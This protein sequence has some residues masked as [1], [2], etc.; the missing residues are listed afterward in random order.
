[1]AKKNISVLLTGSSGFI[2]RNLLEQIG[3]KYDLL[4][5]S[6]SELDL[7]SAEAVKKYLQAH[8]VDVLVHAASRGVIRKDRHA[9]GLADANMSMFFNL[10][11]CNGSYR[12]M[13]CLGSGAEYD[14][15]KPIIRAREGEF[16]RSIPGD[17]YGVYKY[18]CARHIE[19]SGNITSLRLFGCFGKYEDY[20]TR[21]ISNA[22]CKS[23]F[24]LPITIANQNV[25]F[26]YLYVDD[27][28]Q[29]IE[30]FIGH[31]GAHKFYNV[32]PDEVVDLQHIAEEVNRISGK[33]LP[34]IVKNPIM[35]NE[36]SGDNSR[37]KKEIPG[38]RFTKIDE[39]MRRLYSWYEQNLG[40]IDKS[41]LLA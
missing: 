2:G 29:V 24:N 28:A 5:P 17:A 31:E 12:K 20:E 37:L 16:G 35:G 21:F 25:R 15:S 1:L 8:P 9:Q 22:I 36:Y 26:S 27:L 32:T 11:A 13:I 23:L 30:H 33:N 38:I 10:A 14:K 40:K 3:G 39:A 4:A 7:T 19:N 34:I 18:K 6:S 41:K